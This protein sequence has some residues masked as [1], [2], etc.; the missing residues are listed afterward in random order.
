[1]KTGIIVY[2]QTGHTRQAARRLLDSLRQKGYDSQLAEVQ[3]NN[4][5]PEANTTRLQY[6]N[7][8]AT[9]P[10]DRVVFASPVWAFSLSGVMKGYLA[11]LPSL[12]GKKISLFVTHQLPC[13]W[14]GAN[15]AIRQMK[16]LCEEK[17]GQVVSHAVICWNEKRREKDIAEMLNK[18]A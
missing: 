12:S 8:P 11:G 3:V 16:K 2:S 9:D 15:A 13:P 14:M 5:K 4:P 17:G 7:Q 10:Y 6:T 18:L 1:M